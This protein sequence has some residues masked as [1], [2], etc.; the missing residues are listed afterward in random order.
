MGARVIIPIGTRSGRLTVVENERRVLHGGAMKWGVL[1]E[2]DCGAEVEMANGVFRYRGGAH[3]REYC[4][5]GCPLRPGANDKGLGID[6]T[7]PPGWYR[8]Y[9]AMKQ[10]CSPAATGRNF[11]NYFGRGIRVCARWLEHPMHFY[12]DMGDRPEGMTLD[13]IEVEG[14]YEPGNCRWATPR[15][16][17]RNKRNASN[18]PNLASN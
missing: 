5:P 2:C 16:Q 13:R 12:A 17:A 15:E 11:E 6:F 4:S 3:K 10:R 8:S 1:L 18:M 14:H 9:N 7:D